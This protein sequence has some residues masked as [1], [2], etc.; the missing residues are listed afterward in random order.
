MRVGSEIDDSDGDLYEVEKVVS[1]SRYQGSTVSDI[2]ITYDY[3]VVI[4]KK[5]IKYNRN[6]TYAHLARHPLPDGT[7][8]TLSGFGDG[9]VLKQTRI[10]ISNQKK[11]VED[12]GY[13][14]IV[15][16]SHV[17][18]C[19]GWLTANTTSCFGDSGG[20]LVY[21][22]RTLYGIVSWGDERCDLENFPSVYARVD[23][24]AEWFQ[25]FINEYQ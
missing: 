3:G 20:P 18:F 11:C 14:P 13:I 23:T 22:T 5:P 21:G 17:T 19:A 4:L 16:D 8:L 24:M 10:P 9:R 12:Y 15:L 25:A 1:H 2:D 7:M 6:V